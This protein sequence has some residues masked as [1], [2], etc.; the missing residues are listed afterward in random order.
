[1]AST[2]HSPRPTADDGVTL[3]EV[4]VSI[5]LMTV[6]LALFTAGI[7]QMFRVTNR[8]EAIGQAQSQLELTFIGL[9]RAVRYSA[10]ISEPA[11]DGDAWY[12][13]YLTTVTG[14]NRCSQLRLSRTDTTLRERSWISGGAKNG[15]RTLA[16]GLTPIDGATAPFTV[17]S[18]HKLPQL[19]L[20]IAARFGADAT[21]PRSATDLTFT[22]IN[23]QYDEASTE[24]SP[25]VGSCNEI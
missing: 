9:D 2:A 4:A 17:D 1:M 15:W 13:G 25:A 5:S 22:A 12:V 23:A 8:T 20:R 19:R 6:F 16:S 21:M 10:G 18:A 11:F 24:V 3:L 14:E 7:V